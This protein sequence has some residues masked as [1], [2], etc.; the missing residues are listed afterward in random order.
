[1][2][3]CCI[4]YLIQS[5]PVDIAT[6]FNCLLPEFIYITGQRYIPKNTLKIVEDLFGCIHNIYNFINE[7]NDLSEQVFDLLHI[8]LYV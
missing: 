5:N 6:T 1:M 7:R 2:F 3:I 4:Y 8:I